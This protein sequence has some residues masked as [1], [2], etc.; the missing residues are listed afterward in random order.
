MKLPQAPL[1]IRFGARFID[2]VILLLVFEISWP[3][4]RGIPAFLLNSFMSLSGVRIRRSQGDAVMLFT[5]MLV[6]IVVGAVFYALCNYSSLKRSGQSLGKRITKIQIID[7]DENPVVLSCDLF[8]REL[9]FIIPASVLT[10]AIA[11]KRSSTFYWQLAVL[12]LVLDML[13]MFFKDRRCIHD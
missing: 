10:T 9:F 1:S 6:V 4:W 5:I 12:F 8:L 13:P 3:L 11:L 7:R 2:S